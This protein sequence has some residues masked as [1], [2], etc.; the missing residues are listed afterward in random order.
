MIDLSENPFA[1]HSPDA[2]KEVPAKTINKLFISDHTQLDDV[3]EKK[4]T[5]VWGPRGS[6]K[7]FM[8]RYLEPQCRFEEHGSPEKFFESENPFIGIYTP[9][10]KGEIDKTELDL[11]DDRASQVI[12]EHLLNLTV[13]EETLSTLS[14]QFPDDYFDHEDRVEFCRTI[15]GLFDRGSISQSKEYASER[16]EQSEHPF[17]WL[18]EVFTC[19]KRQVDQYLRQLSLNPDAKYGG[20]TS[21]YHDFLL[22]LMDNVQKLLGNQDIPIYVFLDDAFHLFEEQQEVVNTWIANRDQSTL[23][24]K[25]SSTK[26]GYE[27]FETSGRGMIELTHDYTELDFE[28]LYTNSDRQYSKKVRGIVEKRLEVANMATTDV[29]EFL[30]RSEFETDLL[31]EIKENLK[32]EWLE[33]GEPGRRSDYVARYAN[34]RLFQRLAEGKTGKTYSGFDEMVHISSGVVRNF[35]QPC[36]L[37]FNKMKQGGK[38]SSEIDEIPPSTQ[39]DVLT[40]SSENFLREAPQKIAKSLPEEDMPYLDDLITLVRSLGKLFYERL[41]D[42]DSRE[43]RIF[44]FT[45]KG[46]I[47]QDSD[48][49]KVLEL[50]ERVQYFKVKTYSTKEGG[51]REDWYILNRR[52]APMFKLDPT[53]FE[54]RMTLTPELLEVGCKDP[55][56]FVRLRLDIDEHQEPLDRFFKDD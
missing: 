41:H 11:L 23:C 25:V 3:R 27:T 39:D 8:L 24:I 22:P 40:E 29:E 53:G 18:Q 4:H 14:E 20:A 44:S 42:E 6:G 33:K 13:A 12:T 35:L 34:A 54:G 52:L 47:P 50:G 28:K 10:K 15:M 48:L 19:E 55:D 38:Q 51:G 37:M 16:Y 36:Q 5:F 2:L 45:V 31:E 21:G 7:S 1:V 49:N 43:P 30:P 9:C 32:E 17:K 56:E 46:K 26:E